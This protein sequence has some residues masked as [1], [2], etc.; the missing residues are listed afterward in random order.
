MVTCDC[1]VDN[2]WKHSCYHRTGDLRFLSDVDM[3]M[4]YEPF[5]KEYIF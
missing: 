4:S 5:I 3:P 1:E 2:T